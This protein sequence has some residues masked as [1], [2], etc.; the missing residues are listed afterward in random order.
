[1]FNKENKKATNG[2]SSQSP[3]LNM[4]S[5][6][7]KLKGTINS[8]SDIRVAGKIIG[9]AI[10]KGKL[11]VTSNG[12]LEGNLKASEADIAGK[13]EGELHISD[14]LILR[15]SAVVNGDIYTK[16]LIVEEGAQING[17]CHMGADSKDL[18]KKPDAVN[19]RETKLKTDKTE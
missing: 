1:M 2:M 4:I 12:I 13:I 7:T 14:K 18:G 17:S 10:S 6:G 11:I 9:E 3:S 15:Q 8:Q 5:E 19:A 16:T